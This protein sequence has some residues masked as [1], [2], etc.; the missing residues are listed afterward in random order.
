MNASTRDV[1]DP[2]S[3]F[4]AAREVPALVRVYL[5]RVLPSVE[6][7][8]RKVRIMQAGEMVRKPGGRPLPFTA[9]EEFV[10]EEV[11][12]SWRARFP[13]MPLVSM[14]VLDGSSQ[15]RDGSRP[16]CSA[17]RSCESAGAKRRR[18]KRSD[19]SPSCPG[20]RTP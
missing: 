11:A 5:E 17:S 8:P 18:E 7:V 14:R 19:T 13:V 4:G 12:F 16:D 15:A 9:V 20:C 1:D 10:V 6:R 3:I 2:G